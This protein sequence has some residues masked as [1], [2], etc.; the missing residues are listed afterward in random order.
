MMY[1][2]F[3]RSFISQLGDSAEMRWSILLNPVTW[4]ALSLDIE[5]GFTILRQGP[6]NQGLKYP[7]HLYTYLG[8]EINHSP[9]RNLPCHQV[10]HSIWQP[11]DRVDL[12]D[13]LQKPSLRK[14]EGSVGVFHGANERTAVR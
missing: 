11:I 3:W 12:T 13:L 9:S 2:S 6:F 5:T 4:L 8:I 1:D 7:A 14:I 10:A